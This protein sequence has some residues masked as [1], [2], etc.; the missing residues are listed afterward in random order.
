M[1]NENNILNSNQ[2][3][4]L[5]LSQPLTDEEKRGATDES[6]KNFGGKSKTSKRG[7]TSTK[8]HKRSFGLGALSSSGHGGNSLRLIFLYNIAISCTKLQ[9][10]TREDMEALA[11]AFPKQHPADMWRMVKYLAHFW[12]KLGKL[13]GFQSAC[14]P[15]MSRKVEVTITAAG[16]TQEDAHLVT[17]QIMDLLVHIT[18]PAIQETMTTIIIQ[19]IV[20]MQ[21]EMSR[22][23]VDIR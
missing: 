9:I 10:M 11:M 3:L 7:I 22:E 18:D 13:G 5:K 20:A 15:F 6:S 23:S 2:L 1:I 17:A 14:P 12:G 8:D 19:V 4:H 21:A 16:D